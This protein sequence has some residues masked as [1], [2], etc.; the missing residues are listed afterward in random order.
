[1]SDDG[2]D[3]ILVVETEPDLATLAALEERVV[4]AVVAGANLGEESE[5]AVVVRD[6][7]GRLVG[8]VSGTAWGGCCQLQAMWVDAAH[9]GRGWSRR[10][11]AEAE[12]EARREG[13]LKVMFLAYDLVLPG[14]Y[15]RLGYEVAGVVPDC[16]MGSALRWYVKQLV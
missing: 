14:F 8:G 10:L 11:I 6:A 5:F 3:C 2:G 12:A 16:P 4:D 1:M 13:C 15:A 7:H 9:R